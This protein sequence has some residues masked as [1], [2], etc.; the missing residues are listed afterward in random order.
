M[1]LAGVCDRDVNS[2]KKIVSPLEIQYWSMTPYKLGNRAIK[3]SAKPSADNISGRTILVSENY[4]KEAMVE[5]LN[6][7]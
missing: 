4:L 7:K 5:H 6:S 2:A 1:A 3:F